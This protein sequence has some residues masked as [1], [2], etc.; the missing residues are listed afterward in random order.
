MKKSNRLLALT[1]GTLSLAT[2]GLSACRGGGVGGNV[3]E[4]KINPEYVYNGTHIY[5]TTETKD[6]L[7]KDG[8]TDYKLVVPSELTTTQEI[9]NKEFKHLFKKATKIDLEVVADDQVTNAD[10]GKY[11]SLGR[12]DLLKKSGIEVDYYKLT[13]DG[14]K[15]VTKGDDIYICGGMDAGTVFGVYTFMNLTFNYETYTY[16]TMVID[17]VFDKKLL[18]Y[19]VTDIPDF[20][21]RFHA[22]DITTYASPNYDEN[23]LAW[24]RY[25]RGKEATR[26][27]YYMT[28]HEEIG[29]PQSKSGASTNAR[30]WFP[31][32]LY[33][34]EENHPESYHPYWFSTNGGEQL[35]FSAHGDEKE[36]ELMVETAFQ[37]VAWLLTLYTPETHPNAN[38]ITLTHM[39]NQQYCT[40]AKCYEISSYYG[41]SQAAVQILFMNDLTEK[42]QA[43]LEANKDKDWYRE[44]F[45]LLFFAYNHNYAPPAKYD[46]VKKEYVPIDDKVILHD[47]LIAFFCRNSNGQAVHD[48]GLNAQA[49]GILKGWAAV[50]KNIRY[51]NYGAAFRNYMYDF[52]SYQYT[53]S[54]M[55]GFWCN[56]SDLSWFTQHQD[57]NQCPN[58]TW[59][60]LRVYLDSKMS[61]DTSLSQQE[62]IEKYMNA[63]Y[64]EAAPT[65]MNLFLSARAFMRH[66]SI[67]QHELISNGDGSPEKGKV[68]YFPIGIVEGWI[69]Y[70]DQAL[71]DI[72]IHKTTDP[73]LY[74][75]IA[76]NIEVEGIQ[77]MYILLDLH[78]NTLAKE[79]KQA[80]VNRI[81]HDID[82]L[83][84]SGMWIKSNQNK[85]VDWVNNLV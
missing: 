43:H 73:E 7:V 39:D 78:G 74:D 83:N 63:V 30:R 10:S 23:M 1:L 70:I 84:I 34:D 41:G 71:K 32:W 72:E 53:T 76:K 57:H 81:K 68:E 4:P 17:E 64:K 33:K 50:A 8:R 5:T 62:L 16:N 47:K 37:K 67:D 45:K 9:A 15:I 58:T 26:G 21:S 65:M 85:L 20:K 61:W 79:E 36:Y 51:W 27:M 54:E 25:Y 28:V 29:N 82:W 60:H 14:H 66:V 38:I 31:E 59:N 2:V 13:E 3:Q 48:E 22:S 11:I 55:Y 18:N 56:M 69:K 24:R 6:Y 44:D 42:V 40:C 77:Y 80:Y 12:T 75:Q 19:E 46:P 52:D 49:A 35:C